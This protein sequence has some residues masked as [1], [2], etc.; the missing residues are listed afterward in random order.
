MAGYLSRLYAHIWNTV[1]NSSHDFSA[2]PAE[3]FCQTCWKV[4]SLEKKCWRLG[5][6]R[7][8]VYE[9]LC[10]CIGK[11]CPLFPLS[12]QNLQN[13][14]AGFS[15][16]WFSWI[17]LFFIY[18]RHRGQLWRWLRRLQYANM[19]DY[20]TQFRNYCWKGFTLNTIYT[21]Y[22]KFVPKTLQ[23]MVEMIYS[24]RYLLSY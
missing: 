8:L 22:K 18:W 20:S 2:K 14:G 19:R 11:L 21:M 16:V 12:W 17:A 4:L 6:V 3:K 13:Y 10:I 5:A 1:A 7:N 23:R 24:T 15:G 9:Q